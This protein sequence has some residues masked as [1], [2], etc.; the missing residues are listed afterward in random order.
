ME[1]F[2]RRPKAAAASGVVAAL[3][4]LTLVWLMVRDTDKPAA[5]EPGIAVGLPTPSDQP[6]ISDLPTAT[7]SAAPTSAAE[8]QAAAQR[9]FQQFGQGLANGGGGG[10]FTMPGL[11]GG[12]IYQSL[13][14]H[15]VTMRITS[16]API[17]TIGYVVPTSLR[18]SSGVV[19]NVQ[20]SWSLTT[21]AY[22][23]PDY[24]QLFMQAGARGFPITCTITVDGKVTERRS[25]EG[26]YGQM[27]CQG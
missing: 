21:T 2:R 15:T 20:R 4:V 6:T 9:A 26:P 25:T 23:D 24:A 5:E 7:A 12:S 18:N 22:G 1:W 13:P 10:T 8:V 27:I 3:V 19:K 14:R 11:Q 17:G 16:E